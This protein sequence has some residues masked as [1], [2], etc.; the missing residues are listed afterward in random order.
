MQADAREQLYRH[1]ASSPAFAPTSHLTTQLL[2]AWVSSLVQRSIHRGCTSCRWRG[3]G[4]RA[5]SRWGPASVK[6]R[7]C[8]G[9]T[10]GRAR[11]T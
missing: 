8:R 9:R 7:R 11:R 4:I 6:R 5:R 10:V 3:V 1:R 2:V